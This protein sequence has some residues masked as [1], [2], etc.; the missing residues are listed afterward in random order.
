MAGLF[1]GTSDFDLN[2][3]T[4]STAFT[5]G[6]NDGFIAKYDKNGAFQWRTIITGTGSDFN[7][8][9]PAVATNGTHVWL[10]GNINAGTASTFNCAIVSASGTTA[11]VANLG[12]FEAFVTKLDCAA[13]NPSWYK[14]FGGGGTGIDNAQGLAIDP[15]G[16]AYVTGAYSAAF[17]LDGVTAPATAGST[18]FYIAK[19]SPTGY[20]FRFTRGGSP[21]ADMQ[22]NASGV[23][24]VAGATPAIIATGAQNIG[25]G[26]YGAFTV[27]NSSATA[28]QDA[29]LLELDTTLSYT[30]VLLLG[31]GT[32][33]NDEITSAVYDPFSGGVYVCGYFNSATIT[34]PGVGAL[35][36]TG[37]EDMFI[38]RYSTS[39]N[40]FIWAKNPTGAAAE[41]FWDITSDGQGGILAS[42]TTSSTSV[43]FGNS[44]VANYASSTSSEIVVTRYSTSGTAIWAVGAGG[45]TSSPDEGRSV[46]SYVQTSPYVQNVWVAGNFQGSS[47]FNTTTLIN[48]G[49][50][51]FYLARIND[52][53]LPLSAT[54]SQVNLTCNG[55]CTGSATVVASGGTSPYSYSWSPAGGTGAT[56]TSLCATNYTVTITDAASSSITKTFTITQPPAIVITPI[57]QTNI[58]CF[59]GNSGAAQVTASGGTG[60]LSYNWTPGNPTGDGTGSVTGLTAQVYTVTVTDANLCAAT[61]T[62]NITQ[63]PALVTSGSQN[64][65]SC[66]GGSNGSATV[67]VTGG[68]PTYSYNWT[69]GNPSGD[70]TNAVTGLTAQTYTVTVTD[71]NGCQITRTFNI[72]QPPTPVS[73]TTVVTNVS[74]FGSSNGAINLTPTGGTG[75]YTFNW[76]PSGPTTEDRTG[77]VAGTYTVQITDVNGCTGTVTTSVTQPTSPVS[78]T[79]V[80]TNVSCF[81]GSNGAINLTPNGGTGPYTFNWL[82]SGPTTEDRTGLVAGTYTVQ[83][84]DVNGC[85][86]TVTAS[87]TQPTSPVSGTTVVTNVAC[88]GG[89]NGAINLTPTGG[90]GPYT[91]NWLPSGPTTEDRTGLVAGTYTVVVTDV[92]GCTG[93]VTASVTQPSTPVSGTTVVTNVACFGGSNGAINLTPTGGTGPY[94]F[95]WLPSGP[96][97][98]DR[99][100]LVAGTYTVVVT[101]VNGC[102]GTV[103]AS[104]TQPSTPV[105]GTTVVTNVACFGGSNGAINLTPTGGTGPY[106]FNWLP[107]GPTTE[108]R[109]GLVAGTYTVVVTDVNGCTGT[110]TASVTQPSTPVSGTTVVTNVACFG[111]SNGAINL[112]P[113]G[114]TGPYTFNWLPSGPTTED[115]T[116]LVAGTYT[117]Q[118]TDVNGCTG[119]VTAS[120]TQPTSPVSG[121]TVVTN[122]ACFGGSNGAI[123]LTPNGGTG[124]YTFN[125]LPSGPTTEDRTGLVAGTYTVQITD[126]NGCTSTVT[127]SVTQPTSPVSG[128]RVVTNV[129]CF[130]GSNGA[131][132]LTPSGGTGPYTFNWLPSGPTTEDRTGLVA[133][134]YTVIITDVNGCTGTVTASV[135]QPTSPVSGTT[136]VT[137]V[138]CF[139]GSNGAINLTPNGGTGPYTFNWLPSGPTTEDRTGLTAGTYTVIITDVNG[140]TSTVTASVTQPTSPVSGTTVVTNVACFG[141]S[142]GAINLTPN[143]GTGPYTF[144]WLPSGPTTEDRTGLVAG[145]YTVIIT[146]VNGCTGT[147]TASVTQPTSPVSGTT[148]VT[149]VACF[150][151]SNGAI[152]LTPNGG[153]GPYTFNWLPSG[154]TTEDRTGLVAGTYTV[155]ITDVN[156]CTGTVTASVTQPTS[157]VSGTTV[158]TNVACFGGSNGAINLTPNGGT[159]P[160]TFNWLPSGP[161]TE[162]RTGLTAGTYTVI[163]TDVNGCTSTVTAS[164]TQPST[165]VSGTTV[166]TN[167]ACFGGSNGAINLTPSGGTGPYT[168][169]WLPSGPTT[170]DRTGL[171]AGTYTVQIT[172]VNGCTGTVTA[173][174]TQPT[175]PVSGTTV[176]TNVACF[177][178]SNGAINLTPNGGTG[179]YTFNW[180]PSGPTTEDRTG[181]VAG[182][183]TVIITDVN[184]CT[185]TVTASVTQ[186]TSPVSG[187]TVVTNVACFGG[188][189]GAINLTPNGGT[190]PY[191]F[192][193][194]PS[195]PTTEDRT[196][197][198]AGTYSVQITDAN[199]C[200]ATV[201]ASVTQ[202]ATP[203]SGTTVVTNV[204]CFGGAT[205]AINLTPSGGTGP[206]TFNW[207]PSGPTTED[208]TGLVAG[209]YTVQITDV[210]GCTGTVTASVTQPTSPVSGTT[211]VT[212][213]ACFGGSNGAINLTPSGGTGPYTFN[214][215]PSGPTTEDRTGLVAGTYTVQITDVNGCTGTVTASVTQPTSPVSGTTVVT[216][217]ACFGGS[218]GAINLTPNGG[219][220]PYTFNWLPSGPTTEDRTGLA[221]GTYS[222][223]ITDVNGC[224]STV[225][226]SVTQPTSPVSGTTVV[227]NV[228][229]FG[230]NTGAINLTPSG[231]TGPYTFNWLPSGPTTED[232]TGL[233]AGTYSVQITDANGCT[234]T[235][236]ASV[237]QPTS[238][239]SGTTVV[240]NVSC[241]GGSNGAI[242]L[243]PNGGTGPYTFNWLPSGPTTEDR[244]GLTA[245]TYSVQITDVNGCTST[246]TVSVT[247]PASPVSGTTVVTNVSCFGGSNGAINLTPS[248]GTPGYTFNW[249]PSGPTT[250]DRTGLAA[251]TYSV[252]ITDANGCSSTLS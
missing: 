70:G 107:S 33:A 205:G 75:P 152:N 87:V 172:D 57:S 77:L 213:V 103:T 196:G 29:L 249:L 156:G 86:S 166:V 48:D 215:L 63:P 90:T 233:T 122:V 198:T 47:V 157:P 30:N 206:Y 247:Q 49:L 181:L 60:A 67:T 81:G 223:I 243:T 109:T 141:G 91:F 28:S 73:G 165:P 163:I 160:Y 145:T 84:T 96:T 170:E 88:F 127:A 34:F 46:A 6:G 150:G 197:L 92:N 17:T 183:Y 120:V 105:S 100:G 80:V 112:T 56:A 43:S 25:A 111:G 161:T 219:T 115:R 1:S 118:I 245:G 142:N 195:G 246:V 217:V 79:T 186:P 192:N 144:N 203:V 239:V 65:V 62:F 207:L 236:T 14:V 190:G 135:T 21:A 180:L 238:P 76:L 182:T 221:A 131:I 11:I 193:W 151:G 234:S 177:G 143:G 110:V 97:T 200:T 101:D 218:N 225:T 155:I 149:N 194:L 175:S 214:W 50:N 208:R 45:N 125:W 83:I 153:T 42:G 159:G 232:R 210:N 108:D 18:D 72:T 212:N 133:G 53:A 158:V 106:T 5:S 224:T 251:G 169:N 242:N 136:V 9:H 82:P 126:V 61:R 52:L 119:T 102:T 202:P 64:N 220:G 128:T 95:N 146:D 117:V 129:S 59:G 7:L 121:T 167:V 114:G 116:G 130:G 244:T 3:A 99:T 13:G 132:N 58:A 4:T 71:A 2:A 140:C 24:Y 134:T 241:F 113:T 22:V 15:S 147:V 19:L 211:V 8:W 237:T 27:T 178:G 227:T 51:D 201:T 31:D 230:G 69:P 179:P 66:F 85:T 89:S 138:S 204:A 228:A 41:R 104:V 250:E 199:G 26:T 32:T 20:M 123:N 173:S 12:G 176:V 10:A 240:T 38:A 93:T 54:Q 37:A 78:G 184:G 187:T 39:G 222:V 98:E 164:V 185:S 168:F 189:N 174:V 235:V 124:P 229:C 68:V 35:T 44:V 252:Q 139:G 231:G 171:V 191:T 23:A 216:N 74:C 162:D 154:P 55:V 137:N 148:V 248:G 209:T 188:S 36:T 94:T 16:C 40:N 226:A